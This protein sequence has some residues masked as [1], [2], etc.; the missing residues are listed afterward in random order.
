MAAGDQIN[1]HASQ[2]RTKA[3]LAVGMIRAA[4]VKTVADT[5][6]TAR[7]NAP[8]DTGLLRSSISGQTSAARSQ[9]TGEVNA[10]ADYAT[11]VEHGTSRM[12]PQ[13]YMRPAVEQHEP[14]WLSAL[15][16]IHGRL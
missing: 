8:V 7:R 14:M 4:T 6:S 5:K 16:Q 10:S 3:G 12:A 9:V 1:N 2:F 15:D 13:P 11:Y